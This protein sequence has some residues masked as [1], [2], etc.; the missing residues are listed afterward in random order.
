MMRPFYHKTK[1]QD[2]IRGKQSFSTEFTVV[3][4]K[5]VENGNKK[6]LLPGLL[7]NIEKASS[8]RFSDGLAK[9]F[10]QLEANETTSNGKPTSS[11]L[12]AGM[13][14]CGAGVCAEVAVGTV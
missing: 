9:P 7:S 4:R 13:F 8:P 12:R 11:A 6:C 5:R 3:P 14:R 2:H 10:L 1:A